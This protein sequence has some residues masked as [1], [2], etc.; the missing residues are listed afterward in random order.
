[1]GNGFVDNICNFCCCFISTNC[2]IYQRWYRPLRLIQTAMPLD[3]STQWTVWE[4]TRTKSS[5]FFVIEL[6]RNEM[7]LQQHTTIS[8]A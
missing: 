2:R 8:T 5:A 6:P 1:V 7:S 4:L 3:C